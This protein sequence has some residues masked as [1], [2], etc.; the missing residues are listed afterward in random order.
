MTAPATDPGPFRTSRPRRR[1]GRR[2][3]ALFGALTAAALVA[4]CTAGT[5]GQGGDNTTAPTAGGGTTANATTDAGASAAPGS[6]AGGAG[7]S[8]APAASGAPGVAGIPPAPNQPADLSKTFTYFPC[9][10]WQSTWSAN[11]YNVNALNMANDFVMMRLGIGKFPSLTEYIPQLAE[12]W[13]IDGDKITVT[14]RPGLKWQDGTP[15]TSK[16]VY[17]TTILNGLRGDKFWESLTDVAVTDDRTVTYTVR[18]G[19]PIQLV[20]NSILEI[21]PYQSKLYGKFATDAIKKDLITYFGAQKT[22]PDKAAKSAEFKRIGDAFKDLAAMKVD[23]LVGNGPFTLDNVT[24]KEAKLTRWDGFY[25]ADN[26][27]F[28]GIRFLN[29]P[30]ETVYSQL[31]TGNLDFSNVYLSPPLLKRW[32]NTQ[33]SELALPQGFGFVMSFNSSRKPLDIKEVRQ[34]LAYVIPRQQMTEAAY[35]SSPDA[36]G[37]WKEINTG[38]PPS[39]DEIYLTPDQLGK[40]NKYPVDTQKATELLQ[41]KGFTKRDG[42]WFGPDGKQFTLTFTVNS[43]TSD[44]VTAFNSAS[45]SLS[46]FGI[47]SQVKAMDGAQQDANQRNGDFDIGMHFVGGGNPLNLYNLVLGPGFNFPAQGNY[48]GKRG[49]GFGPKAD[50]PGVGEVNVSSTIDRDARTTPPGDEM[51][52][53]VWSWAQLVNEDVPYIWYAT[54]VYQFSY[55]TARF[56]NWP[57]KDDK[58]TSELWN[59]IGNDLGGGLSLAMQLGYVAPKS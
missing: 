18:K 42:K 59:I 34:A 53:K 22:D 26:I 52:K 49:I 20:Q 56:D 25:G 15:L 10:S 46:D 30:N 6:A 58:N 29:G 41:G 55:S 43:Q 23:K 40:L 12:S 28:G 2:A 4:S 54:K 1:V 5:A 24:T 13:K 39:L 8:G 36:G 11:P 37:A 35:G 47:D 48:A 50:L 7:A 38:L 17:D 57:A 3:L 51:K 21:R 44:I 14:L 31:F 32:E 19:E 33:G 16:D 45:K 9:C 27:K